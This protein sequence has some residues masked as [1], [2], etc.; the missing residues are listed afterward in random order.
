MWKR[1]STKH[2]KEL[3][4]EKEKIR[5]KNNTASPFVN[6]KKTGKNCQGIFEAADITG[7]S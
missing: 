7:S 5:E 3:Q 1:L 4:E 2:D 6:T